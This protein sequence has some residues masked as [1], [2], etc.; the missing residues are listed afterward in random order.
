VKLRKNA[1]DICAVLCGAYGREATKVS[2]AF[3]CH[4]QFKE[5]CKNMEEVDI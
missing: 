1:R 3:E 5:G 2:N 4:K